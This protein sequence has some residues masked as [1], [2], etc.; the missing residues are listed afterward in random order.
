MW[1]Q[2]KFRDIFIDYPLLIDQP[3]IK[4]SGKTGFQTPY[5]FQS[6]QVIIQDRVTSWKFSRIYTICLDPITWLEFRKTNRTKKLG[7]KRTFH[8]WIR[9]TCNFGKRNVKFKHIS[10]WV[11]QK[12]Q[13][14]YTLQR[15]SHIS[16]SIN[17]LR[18]R[19]FETIKIGRK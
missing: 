19:G 9:K 1:S 11:I 13:L 3:S 5:N 18:L 12:P 2:N 17:M 7:H 14:F 4:M 10:G 16:N 6:W 15:C 8:K